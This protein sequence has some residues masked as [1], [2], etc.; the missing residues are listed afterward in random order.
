MKYLRQLEREKEDNVRRELD[1]GFDDIRALLLQ[2]GSSNE[3]QE[4]PPIPKAS[5]TDSSYDR[6]VRELA[7]ESR[8]KPKDRTKTEEELAAEAKEKLEKAERQRL[9][10]MQ[11]LDEES[12]E[13]DKSR[14][15]KRKLQAPSGDDLDDDFMADADVLDGLGSG[16]QEDGEQAEPGDSDE[17]DSD[18][19]DEDEGTSDVSSENGEGASSLSDPGLGSKAHARDEGLPFVFPCPDSHEDWLEIVQD[20][21][22]A[23]VG[24]VV[25][26]IL[27]LYHPSLGEGNKEKLQVNLP[28]SKALKLITTRSLT[29]SSLI[30]CFMS[31]RQMRRSLSL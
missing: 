4:A 11:G 7:F 29:R 30:M 9:R 26:R 10:R 15:K 8:A 18:E 21:D 22:D 27:A 19:D 17:D 6:I 12:D 14:R 25:E 16:L 2:G 31:P 28:P 23:N 1:E 20:I 3:R 24:T 5:G 13:D